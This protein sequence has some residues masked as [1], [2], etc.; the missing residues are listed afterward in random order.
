[1]AL[2]GLSGA[3]TTISPISDI[4]SIKARI[5]GAAI[6]SSLVIKIKGLFFHHL[7]FKRDSIFIFVRQM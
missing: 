7:G 5:P 1:M 3:T 4:T 2:C 6:P